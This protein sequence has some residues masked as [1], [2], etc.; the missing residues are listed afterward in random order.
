[1]QRNNSS[2]TPKKR[3]VRKF[4][5]G[6]LIVNLLLIFI[7]SLILNTC[8][9]Y[10]QLEFAFRKLDQEHQKIIKQIEKL[11]EEIEFAKSPDF[12]EIMARQ[13]HPPMVKEGECVI[14]LPVEK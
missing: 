6:T 10:I 13:M 1:M 14:I 5:L 7:L 12:L 8:F 4:R 9:K 11:E 2:D 3:T